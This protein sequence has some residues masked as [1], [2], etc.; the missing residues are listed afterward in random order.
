MF[1]ETVAAAIQAVEEREKGCPADPR[2]AAI[3]RDGRDGRV[4]HPD[5]VLAAALTATSDMPDDGPVE[6][7][8]APPV[9]RPEPVGGGDPYGEG[10]ELKARSERQA[11]IN[12]GA[13]RFADTFA[14]GGGGYA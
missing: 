2:L 9:I 8:P 7:E 11:W 4:W 1:D 14:T 12:S 3:W 5:A 13:Y 6:P 10:V